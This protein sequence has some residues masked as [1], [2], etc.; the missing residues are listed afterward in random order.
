MSRKLAA[1]LYNSRANKVR[2]DDEIDDYVFWLWR[3]D[4]LT[5]RIKWLGYK[6]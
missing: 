2:Y 1:M 3:C 4:G 5:L 6:P